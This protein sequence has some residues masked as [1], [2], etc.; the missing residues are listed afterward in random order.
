MKM[1]YVLELRERDEETWMKRLPK[2]ATD[3]EVL[4]FVQ[5]RAE[6]EWEDIGNPWGMPIALF[7]YDGTDKCKAATNGRVYEHG[8]G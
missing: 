1:L 6:Y 5:M 4:D 2:A 7:K 3:G 8:A